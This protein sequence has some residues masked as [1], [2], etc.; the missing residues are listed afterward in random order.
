MGALGSPVARVPSNGRVLSNVTF[1]LR[2]GDLVQRDAYTRWA[3]KLGRPLLLMSG[4][5]SASGPVPVGRITG[6]GN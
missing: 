5:D 4:G 2:Y 1:T 6:I 3:N